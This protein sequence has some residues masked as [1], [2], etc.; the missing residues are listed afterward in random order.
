M[1]FQYNKGYDS[2]ALHG[3]DDPT[4]PRPWNL[5]KE[6]VSYAGPEKTLLDIG[7]GTGFK[8]L[9]L[10]PYFKNIT[11]FDIC[12]ELLNIAAREMA[13]DCVNNVQLI[14]GDSAL[15][16]FADDQFDVVTCMLSRWSVK[17][18]V[19]V[20]KPNGVVI[21]EHIGCEDK[22]AF[23]A[24]FGQDEAGWRGQYLN[25]EKMDFL[26]GYRRMFEQY[27]KKVI[28]HNGF[29]RTFYTEAGIL[30]L[31]LH[32][33]TI[34]H[35]DKYTDKFLV[36]AAMRQFRTEQG[37]QLEQNRIFIC[38]KNDSTIETSRA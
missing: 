29:W 31:L 20:L 22:K 19:R 33:P 1:I 25:Y 11:G 9:P 12:L 38:A 17:E 14:Q 35:F 28:L 7:C 27:F 5:L 10:A 18:I 4:T 2:S 3:A 21:I 24:I 37:I 15:L 23:K 34:R 6:I 16:P 8:L 13:Y 32:T 30:A 26:N 36:K